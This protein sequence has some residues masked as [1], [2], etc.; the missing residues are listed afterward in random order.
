V[1][2]IAIFPALCVSAALMLVPTWASLQPPRPYQVM[3]L[4][5]YFLALMLL[6]DRLPVDVIGAD[7]IGQ[8]FVAALVSAALITWSVS[9]NHGTVA[10]VAA[11]ALGG[12]AFSIW[13]RQVPGNQHVLAAWY[14]LL[15][16]GCAYVGFVEPTQP[17]VPLLIA[18]LAPLGSWLGWGRRGSNMSEVKPRVA[19]WSCVTLVLIAATVA[20]AFV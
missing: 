2:L 19:A 14:T 5:T 11:S 16:G 20:T 1:A 4:S 6:V 10:L 18:P 3:V 15:I 13:L 12:A 7:V 17:A 9:V 8:M